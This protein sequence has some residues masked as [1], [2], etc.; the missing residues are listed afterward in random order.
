MAAIPDEKIMGTGAALGREAEGVEALRF[1][2]ISSAK[3]LLD[4]LLD[5][6]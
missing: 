2:K 3:A 5:G 4:D 1:K 6:S